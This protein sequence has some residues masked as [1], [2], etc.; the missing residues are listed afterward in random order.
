VRTNGLQSLGVPLRY[1]GEIDSTYPMWAVC[2]TRY[3]LCNSERNASSARLHNEVASRAKR[4]AKSAVKNQ[5]KFEL[6]VSTALVSGL[7]LLVAALGLQANRGDGTAL[8]RQPR[9]L[10]R[11]LTAML[12]VL[13]IVAATL[14]SVFDLDR[15]VK[16]ALIALAL[17]PVPPFLPSKSIKAGGESS[18]AVGLLVATSL[19]SIVYLPLALAL[20][21]LVFDIPLRLSVSH[22]IVPVGWTVFIPLLVGLT[23][24]RF[25]PEF[26]ARVAAPAGRLASLL[27]LFGLIPL[28]ITALPRAM[29]LIGNGTLL[30]MLLLCVVGLGVGHL[31]GEGA[32]GNRAT[33]ALSTAA[34]HPGV[35]MAIARAN[36]PD[37]TLVFPAVLLY[38]VLNTIVSLPYVKWT[39]RQ[40]ARLSST[41]SPQ[42]RM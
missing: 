38:V 15:A 39:T 8:L 5:L 33:L 34:R 35:A 41:A 32:P 17:S 3:D 11:S 4:P 28:L 13:P 2:D 20:L 16:I 23:V 40:S 30:A 14:A 24:K 37:Q 25:A 29:P 12:V 19:I 6:A 9:R 26:A 31:L 21:K 42:Y 18:Y 10:L 27:L 1:G 22:V 7:L 36:F